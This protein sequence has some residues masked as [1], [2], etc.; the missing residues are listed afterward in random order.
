MNPAD[1]KALAL[2]AEAG[3]RKRR[4]MIADDQTILRQSLR[5]LLEDNDDLEVVGAADHGMV[6]ALR[7]DV[8]LIELSMPNGEGLA[9]IREIKRR[10]AQT[11]ALVL[12]THASEEQARAAFSA[13]AD[14]YLPK[15]ATRADLLRA[16]SA[17]LSGE[18]FVSRIGLRKRAHGASRGNG[19]ALAILTAREHQ[20]LK[21]IAAGRRNRDVALEL[22]ISVKTVEK[23]RSNLMRKLKLHNVAAL[24]AFA[25][26]HGLAGRLIARAG[27]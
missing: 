10:S 9:A 5:A 19:S 3:V 13:G 23:H 20:V 16:I 24:T 15:D 4:V 7:P 18:R 14:G 21:L 25:I 11:K 12:T 1:D 26:E 17:V 22:A 2:S 27:R 8:V 6:A